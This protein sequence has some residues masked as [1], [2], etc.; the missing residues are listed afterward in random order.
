MERERKRDSAK[1]AREYV[2]NQKTVRLVEK[3]CSV[4]PKNKSLVKK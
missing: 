3:I 2:Y 1:K 4:K